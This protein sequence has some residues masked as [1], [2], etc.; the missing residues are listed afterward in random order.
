[1]VVV[2]RFKVVK[3]N[4]LVAFCGNGALCRPIE[5]RKEVSKKGVS[6]K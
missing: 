6:V 3:C 4:C 1:M 2:G 5:G